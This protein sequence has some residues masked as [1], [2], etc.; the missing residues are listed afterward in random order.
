MHFILCILR[1]GDYIGC[2]ASARIDQKHL[3]LRARDCES[4]LSHQ[5]L[6]DGILTEGLVRITVRNL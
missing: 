1:C 4:M 5:E 2:Q 3:L 6:L